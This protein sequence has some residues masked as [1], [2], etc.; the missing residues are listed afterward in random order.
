[1]SRS[2]RALLLLALWIAALAILG[3]FIQRELVLGTDLRLFLPSPT[4][5]EQRLLL[6]E[7]GEGPASRVLVIALEG[8]APEELADASR[9]LA[10]ELR[11]SARFRFVT[12]GETS[13][14]ALPESLLAYR[15]LLSPTLDTHAL[16]ADY[17]RREIEVR[18]RDLSSP[19]GAFLE[20]WLPH[21]PTLE[22]LKVLERWR[23]MQEPRREFD[24]WFD[25]DGRRALLLAET[26]APA[27]DPDQQRA[28]LTELDAIFARLNTKARIRMLVSGAGRFSVMMEERTRGDAQ[29][30]GAIATVAMIL[31]LW[32]A[33]RR[34]DG[35]ILSA[36]PLASAGLAGLAAVSALF[37]DV[38]GITLA[39]G[40]T[41]IGVAQDY[42]IHLL[43]HRRADRAPAE[44]ARKLVADARYRRRQH[45]HR[46]L[47]LSIFRRRRPAAARLL[48][49]RRT[50]S[51]GP[52][53]EI[54]VAAAHEC[55]RAGLW[56]LD[57]SGADVAC[58][59]ACS[60][61]PGTRGGAYAALHSVARV[62]QDAALGER[63]GETYAR[64]GGS[65]GP[66]R[67]IARRARRTRRSPP[68][69]HR[70]T[71]IS[72][73]RSRAL[74]RWMGRSGN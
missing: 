24:V 7:I 36:L 70:C 20:P 37:G 8:A 17:L 69:R 31:L 1:M 22:L 59:R 39:F 18:A 64:A 63:S 43:S 58:F 44:V 71:R 13:L 48:H 15:Y 57:V 25:A 12:N 68:P 50:R 6:E 66:G 35:I 53:H 21:D 45:V 33:Y 34:P 74:S 54:P 67:A 55:E 23:P 11:G 62:R 65:A 73:T 56:P 26:Q 52:H 38:H 32:I 49:R 30:L 2:P 5:P 29:R 3:W 72:N 60:P 40:F 51:R 4:T 9:A 16:D 42:P 46:L 28:A 41:L 61:T 27:F 10:D 19:A 14:D 47:H